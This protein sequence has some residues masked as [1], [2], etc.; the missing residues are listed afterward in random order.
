MKASGGI[1]QW[2]TATD[3]TCFG[4]MSSR[5]TGVEHTEEEA[6]DGREFPG[7]M[8]WSQK[9]SSCQSWLD[10]V[11]SA[12]YRRYTVAVAA[13]WLSRRSRYK[14]E[15]FMKMKT[16]MWDILSAQATYLQA[17]VIIYKFTTCPAWG[18]ECNRTF[19]KIQPPVE[20]LGLVWRRK[21]HGVHHGW[22][23]FNPCLPSC[24][25]T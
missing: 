8:T 3:Q 13:L 22:I 11:Y 9:L 17:S 24:N 6:E 14:T 1:A 7:L 15:M 5:K 18:A 4:L 21:D 20:P 10:D 12:G 2:G 25:S 19:S 23:I 16:T